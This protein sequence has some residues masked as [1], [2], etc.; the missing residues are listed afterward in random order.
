VRSSPSPVAASRPDSW[1]SA[2]LSEITVR[3]HLTS[4][5]DK[6]G[7]KDRIELMIFA[8][9]HGLAKLPR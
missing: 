1:P 4:I 8:H 9:R 6:F 2:S 5:F 7:D 3:H